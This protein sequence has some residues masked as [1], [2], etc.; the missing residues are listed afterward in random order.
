[1]L[2]RSRENA[3]FILVDK[4]AKDAPPDADSRA[5]TGSGREAGK[6]KASEEAVKSATPTDR[7]NAADR[8]AAYDIKKSGTLI[9]ADWFGNPTTRFDVTPRGEAPV[10]RAIDQVPVEFKQVE[11]R[12]ESELRKVETQFEKNND[13]AAMKA[14]MKLFKLDVVGHTAV[15]TAVERYTTLV[16]RGRD[17]IKSLEAEGDM[18]GLR[19]MKLDYRGSDLETEI[20]SAVGRINSKE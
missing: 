15:N 4:P 2:F 11:K 14:V 17:R 8:W 3:F 5:V 7:L 19:R 6:E 1:M 13:G 12:L 10:V 20:E 18:A 16:N 9:V